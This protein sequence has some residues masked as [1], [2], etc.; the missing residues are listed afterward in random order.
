VFRAFGAHCQ[1]ATF[2]RLKTTPNP[3]RPK[4]RGRCRRSAGHS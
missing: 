2:R 3:A 1:E 4:Q